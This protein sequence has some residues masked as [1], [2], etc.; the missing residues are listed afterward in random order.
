MNLLIIWRRPL[1]GPLEGLGHESRDFFGPWNSS[2]AARAVWAPKSW[3]FHGPTLPMA[4]VMSLPRSKIIRVKRHI[5]NRFIGNVWCQMNGIVKC[6]I[7]QMVSLYCIL[8]KLTHLEK[9]V[10]PMFLYP[11]KNPLLKQLLKWQSSS[12]NCKFFAAILSYLQ[13][14]HGINLVNILNCP[15]KPVTQFSTFWWFFEIHKKV[16]TLHSYIHT[17]LHQDF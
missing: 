1:C 7:Q 8:N 14:I 9:L 10:T 2:S 6:Q 16:P 12:G 13:L 17:V 4:Q 11:D 15:Y 5:I 3:D